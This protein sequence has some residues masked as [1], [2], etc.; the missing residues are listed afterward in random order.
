MVDLD[1]GQRVA[2]HASVADVNAVLAEYRAR[3]G[4]DVIDYD[5]DEVVDPDDDEDEDLDDCGP[6]G[7]DVPW[8]NPPLPYSTPFAQVW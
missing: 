3:H 7:E 5:P 6:C 8:Q 1:T 4:S 2:C